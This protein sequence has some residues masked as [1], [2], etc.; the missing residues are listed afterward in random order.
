M[1]N[2]NCRIVI[3]TICALSAISTLFILN[4]LFIFSN[5]V[6]AYPLFGNINN[7]FDNSCNDY[8]K[9][10]DTSVIVIKHIINKYE[11][12]SYNENDSS[13]ENE[14]YN[15]EDYLLKK[16]NNNVYKITKKNE[17]NER[18]ENISK[19]SYNL[20]NG[21]IILEYKTLSH[22][23]YHCKMMIIDDQY[24]ENSVISYLNLYYKINTIIDNVF[25]NNKKCIYYNMICN[26]NIDK[27]EL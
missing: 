24:S 22:C 10:G 2:K 12:Y 13:N 14:L 1:I 4:T 11:N 9:P 15:E 7:I 3:F 23:I 20:F 6:K 25:C 21:E 26:S 18:N 27:D 19:K 5:N 8:T 17:K 16:V